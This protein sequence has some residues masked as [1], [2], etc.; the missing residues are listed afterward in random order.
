MIVTQ[1]R[2]RSIYG[3][4]RLMNGETIREYFDFIKSLEVELV[5]SDSYF[6]FRHVLTFLLVQNLPIE[7][8][9]DY[10]RSVIQQIVESDSGLLNEITGT[11]LSIFDYM[12][13]SQEKKIILCNTCIEYSMFTNDLTKAEINEKI[14]FILENGAIIAPENIVRYYHLFK[15]ENLSQVL[16]KMTER[17]LYD[18]AGDPDDC[19]PETGLSYNIFIVLL[20]YPEAVKALLELGYETSVR[21]LGEN[22]IPTTI[23]KLA[24]K[25]LE[26]KQLQLEDCNKDLQN[27]EQDEESSNLL[28]RKGSLQGLINKYYISI[29]YICE[30][31]IERNETSD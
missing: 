2:L 31:M 15:G 5:F 25:R 11:L 17:Q 1:E 19:D 13:M 22:R 24:N 18:I 23:L 21:P 8:F 30:Y 20:H 29:G 6:S 28:K 26:K 4:S 10:T 7:I 27:C 9:G 3:S 14:K 12:L 16:S